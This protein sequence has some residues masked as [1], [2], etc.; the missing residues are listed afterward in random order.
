MHT[1][2]TSAAESPRPQNYFATTHWTVVMAAGRSHTTGA[3]A[4]LD[5]LCQR[6]W[7]PLYAYVRRRGSNPE[8][9][10]DLTQEFFRT[11][12]E[13]EYLK[14]ADREKGRFR[15][16]LLV[17]LQ[18]FL[19]NDWDRARAQKRGG[20]LEHVSLDTSSAETQYQVEAASEISPER[21]YDRRWAFAL[22]GKSMVRLRTEFVEAGKQGE[23][24]QIKECLTADRGSM[25]YAALSQRTGLSE[26]AVR[27]AIHRLRKRFREIFRQEVAQTVATPTEI[28]AEM[29]HLMAALAD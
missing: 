19:A 14:A 1:N 16:F 11:L 4:A 22:L 24:E 28:D 5:E 18:R 29:R 9:A 26:G 25:D 12:L 6:Y 21:I 2:V 7:Y 15:T 13:K 10:E 17:A 3:R 20:R 8:D 23:F 27:V